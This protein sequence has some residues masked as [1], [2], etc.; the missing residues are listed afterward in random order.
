[1]RRI[2]SILL[3][4]GLVLGPLLAT[5]PANAL[6]SG[7]TGKLDESRLPA[8]CRRNGM[9]H[10]V[11][12]AVRGEN[13]ISAQDCCPCMPHALVATA[14]AVAALPAVPAGTLAHPA[15]RITVYG[16][17]DGIRT[18]D[19]RGWPKRGPPSFENI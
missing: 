5:V 15:E 14:P 8:C 6:A 17:V 18:R 13:S 3:A 16:S 9:H 11:S 19:R 2:L 12:G 10:C 1:M 7:W 4:L